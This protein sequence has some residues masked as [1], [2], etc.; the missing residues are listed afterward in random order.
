MPQFDEI[1]LLDYIR[2]YTKDDLD[3]YEK[4]RDDGFITDD[5]FEK[6]KETSDI[7]NE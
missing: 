5:E 3:F 2:S 4:M 1:K 7:D 6:I